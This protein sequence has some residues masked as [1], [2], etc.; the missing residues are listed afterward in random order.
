[1]SDATQ[2]STGTVRLRTR[3]KPG[4]LGCL[5]SLHG[6]LYAEEYGFDHTFEAY[7]AGPLAEFALKASPRER[8]WIAERDDGF[9]GCVAIVASTRET[10]QLRWYLVAPEARGEGLGRSLLNEA[11]AFSRTCGYRA[12]ILWTVSDL[13]AAGH[14]Y[15][16][17]GFRKIQEKPRRT[18]WGVDVIEE[19]YEMKLG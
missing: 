10:A 12:I 14:L 9:V 1:M 19:Q 17:V 5:V 11:V 2:G 3:L 8:L 16:A 4:D 18:R 13:A 7:V 6:R 15:N